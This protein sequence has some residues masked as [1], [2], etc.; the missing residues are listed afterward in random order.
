MGKKVTEQQ[1]RWPGRK[2][3]GNRG[4][5]RRV[6]LDLQDFESRPE[7]SSQAYGDQSYHSLTRTIALFQRVQSVS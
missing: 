3:F 6:E 2:W 4:M 5:K 7:G 1:K